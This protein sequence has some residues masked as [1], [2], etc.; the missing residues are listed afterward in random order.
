ML[1]ILHH[2]Y[3]FVEADHNYPVKLWPAMVSELR[4]LRALLPFAHANLRSPISTRVTICD[5]CLSGLGVGETTWSIDDVYAVYGHDERWRFKEPLADETHRD[6]ALRE[7]SEQLAAL[8]RANPFSDPLS[9]VAPVSAK[10]KRELEEN[11]DFPNI[12]AKLLQQSDWRNL[13][14]S[15]LVFK[16]PVH[17]CVRRERC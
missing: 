7:H 15:P 14:A 1:S 2:S 4:M 9:V 17:L 8:A 13:W 3:K 12:E 16:E 5:A 10:T 11:L 6:R